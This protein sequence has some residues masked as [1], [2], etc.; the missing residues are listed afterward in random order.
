M[1]NT[2]TDQQVQVIKFLNADEK[3]KVE[4]GEHGTFER[5]CTPESKTVK[6]GVCNGWLYLFM[7][8]EFSIE[9]AAMGQEVLL[10]NG[11]TYIR[12]AHA[13]LAAPEIADTVLDIA[14]CLK[15]KV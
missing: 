1:K 3:R 5:Y 7:P 10:C 11:E 13:I 14:N 2:S 12:A 4:L 8:L 15:V 6:L 9:A